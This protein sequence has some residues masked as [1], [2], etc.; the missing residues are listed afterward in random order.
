MPSADFC[1]AVGLPLGR[2]SRAAT[3]SRSPGVSS[4]AFRAQSPNL[5]FAPLMDMDF[6]VSCPLVRH[7]RL[8]SGFC[9]STRT[10]AQRFL[11]TSPRGDSPCVI[12]SPSPPSGWAEDSHLPA[13]EHAQHTTKPLRG[14]SGQPAQR[15]LLVPLTLRICF[16][17]FD[18]VLAVSRECGFPV[19]DLCRLVSSQPKGVS[20]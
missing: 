13:A 19:I 4:A 17:I 14:S 1:S 15:S 3:Q 6:A 8:I 9:P 18:P 12:A 5:R 16:L 2:L 11:Q 7:W 10:F 20:P